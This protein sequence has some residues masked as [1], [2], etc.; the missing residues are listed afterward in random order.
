[1]NPRRRRFLA[2]LP[3]LAAAGANGA[4]GAASSAAGSAA[5]PAAVTAAVTA[6]TPLRAQAAS[7]PPPGPTPMGRRLMAFLDEVDQEDLAL[8]PQAAVLRGDLKRAGEFGDLISDEHCRAAEALLRA[9]LARFAVI[10]RQRLSSAEQVAYDMWQYLARFALR[11]YDEG[12]VRL[13]QQLPIDHLF[14]QHIAFAQFSSGSAGAPYRTVADYEAGLARIDGFVVY[15]DRAIG[16]MRQGLRARRVQPG[17]IVDKVIAQLDEALALAPEASPFH[18]PIRALPASFNEAERQRFTAAYRDAITGKIHPAFARLREFMHAEVRAPSHRLRGDQAPG[19]AALPGGA[20]W[21]EVLL[22]SHTT[23]RLG[24]D[25]IHRT[26]LAEVKRIRGEMARVQAEVG[27]KGTLA[28]FFQHLK[29][30]ARY[31]F[32]TPEAMFAAYEAVQRRVAEVLPRFFAAAPKSRLVFAPVPAEQQASAGG[33]YYI[34]GTPDGTR[35]GTFYLN[36]SELPTRTATRTTA[37]FLH[38]GVPGHHLQGSLAQEDATLPPMLR[39][40]WNAGYG[41]GWALYAEW[42]GHEMAL[43]AG[44]PIQHFGQLDME[45]FRA[46]RLVVDTGLHTQGWSRRRATDYLV[47]NTSLER[48]FCEG[49]VDRYIVWP[50]QA[51]AYKLGELRIR[52]L[53]QRAERTL[54]S[55]F[56]VREFHTQVLNTGAVALAVLERKIDNWMRSKA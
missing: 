55:R 2:T 46:A 27:F 45:I 1:M 6:A 52:A 51:C 41:E 28:E 23:L 44:D 11:Q 36:T 22:E 49:E 8:N 40:A 7:Q 54:G 16:R 30:D 25:E 3:A 12:H 20:R 21:Y 48:T 19:L 32:A 4:G 34:V 14:G 29:T 31:K 50:G 37:L 26:G 47:A 5:D 9:Q 15:L 17:F 53:R 42:L 18:G 39:F 56:D 24:A 35:P 38:E 13:A 10:D 43:Y 33:A